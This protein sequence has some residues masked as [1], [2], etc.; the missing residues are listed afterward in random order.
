MKQKDE[1]EEHFYYY[2]ML[3]SDLVMRLI[4]QGL[5]KEE[6]YS[7]LYGLF[8]T[9]RKPHIKG[10]KEF[11]KQIVRIARKIHKESVIKVLKQE[12]AKKNPNKKTLKEIKE[13]LGK[14]K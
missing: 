11:R 13:Y 3:Q 12:Q 2:S 10:Y 6:I 9:K 5:T 14:L 1:I 7:A 4:E 8:V